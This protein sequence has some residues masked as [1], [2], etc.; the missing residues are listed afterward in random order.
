MQKA[1]F[2]CF[3][4]FHTDCVMRRSFQVLTALIQYQTL[5]LDYTSDT[6]FTE[7]ILRPFNEF[8]SGS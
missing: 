7:I 3:K 4:S 2:A 6:W 8:R 1:K 5:L